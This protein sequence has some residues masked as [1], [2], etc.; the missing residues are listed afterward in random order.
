MYNKV[1]VFKAMS[2]F[3]VTSSIFGLLSNGK[4]VKLYT[5]SNGKM[6]F[7]VTDFGCTITSIMLPKKDNPKLCD[8]VV[9]G[10]STLNKYV[11]SACCFGSLVGRFA[12]RIGK[13]T[14]ELNG[15]RYNLDVNDGENFLHGGFFRYEKQV[16]D[17]KVLENGV[18]FSRLSP[19]GEQGF[20]GNLEVTVKYTLTED[21][22]IVCEY[23]AKSDKDTVINLTNH[24]Y[25]NLRGNG[26]VLDEELSIRSD[27][28]LEVDSG[29]IP[30]GK[31]L[32]TDGTAWDFGMFK[33]LGRDIEKTGVGYDHCYVFEDDKKMK[34]VACLRDEKT[35]RKMT[36]DTNQCG[37]QVY[38]AN[39]IEGE[40]GKEGRVYHKHDGVCLETQSLPDSPNKKEFPSSVLKAGEEYYARTDY[41]FEF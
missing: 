17:S 23:R 11:D 10:Y 31:M 9:L 37:M 14:F 5:V 12:N 7:S 26:S 20:P 2:K 27:K 3:N 22:K 34:R 15:T 4:E 38:T 41:G 8:D 39:F 19:D 28:Y 29:L 36:V 30:T 40:I 33:A 6:A 25:F 1:K 21:N 24:S 32:E 18:E 13:A 35:G 16:W